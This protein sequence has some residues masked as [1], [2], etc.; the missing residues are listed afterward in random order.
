M[1]KKKHY[2]VVNRKQ[3]STT[4]ANDLNEKL[5]KLKEDTDI[6]KTRLLDQAVSLLLLFQSNSTNAFISEMNELKEQKGF[7]SSELTDYILNNLKKE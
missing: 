1:T 4:L 7:N 2:K 5:E 3:L 6:P